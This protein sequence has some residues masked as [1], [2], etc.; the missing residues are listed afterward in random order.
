MSRSVR[1]L[2]AF[3]GIFGPDPSADPLTDVGA[4][5]RFARCHGSDVRFDHRRQ[6]WLLWSGHRWS[7]DADGGILR[8]AIDF[9]RNWQREALDIRDHESR[10]KVVRFGLR[11]ERRD[12]L[13]SMLSLARAIKPIAEPGDAWDSDPW[14]LGVPNGVVDLR[15]GGLRA[16]RRDDR[17][18][19]GAAVAFEP[20][21]KCERW[22]RF[23]REVFGGDEQ[24]ASFAHRAVGYSLSGQTSGQCCFMGHGHGSNGKGT[25]TNTLKYVFGDYAWNTPFATLELRDRASIPND[26][27]AL[28]GRRFVIA[29]ETN[30]GTRLNE[31]RVKALTGC[32]PVT[33]RFL[34]AEYFTFIPVAKFWLS[35]NHK[36]VVK[37]DS[38]GFWRRLRLIPFLQR[39]EVDGRLAGQLNAEAQGILAWAIR[40]C[41][42]WQRE[43]LRAPECVREA[44]KEY[45]HESDPLAAFLEEACEVDPDAELRASEAFEHYL[46]WA[47]L[48]GL[49]EGERLSATK[50]GTRLARRFDRGS[51]RNG[52]VYRGIA[53]RPL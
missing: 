3:E 1:R 46:R 25:F 27:A 16:G 45:E 29:S 53:R 4:A 43:G 17:I 37:D 41:L 47:Q 32:D 42:A 52:R 51:S 33:A 44:T 24:L 40:G 10:S 23:V 22:L 15:T 38:Y 19:L 49:T 21:A 26:V 50:F 18:T 20:G 14:L 35:V 5:E 6:V 34:H 31:A 12:A 39:F 8:L 9:A 30:D 13:N 7:P 36:P 2:Q 48:Q 11:L 28:V